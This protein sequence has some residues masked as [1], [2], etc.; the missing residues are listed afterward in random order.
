MATLATDNNP[1]AST[2]SVPTTT[3]NDDNNNNMSEVNME[4]NNTNSAPVVQARKVPAKTEQGKILSIT[5]S[6]T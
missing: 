3:A 2:T 6:D 4:N 5:V 1:Y